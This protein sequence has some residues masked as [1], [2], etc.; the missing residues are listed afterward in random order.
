MAG[1]RKKKGD[2]L[3]AVYET[4]YQR[5]AYSIRSLILAALHRLAKGGR[6][7]NYFLLLAEIERSV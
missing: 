3:H 2:H 7:S 4:Y 6:R 1:L 5:T